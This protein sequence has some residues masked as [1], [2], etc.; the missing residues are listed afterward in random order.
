MKEINDIYA[1]KNKYK[2][3]KSQVTANELVPIWMYLIVFGDIENLLTE[4]VII[5]DFMLKDTAL[6][7]ESGYHLINLITAI[8]SFKNKENENA[9][10]SITPAFVVT[11]KNSYDSMFYDNI[12]SLSYSSTN[13]SRSESE[14]LFSKFNIFK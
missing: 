10:F 1:E 3:I 11:Q 12:R 9:S 14:S 8:E 5:Q 6:M 7:N 13:S 2:K 4:I